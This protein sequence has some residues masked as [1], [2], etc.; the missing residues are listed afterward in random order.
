MLVLPD[1][2]VLL[3]GPHFVTVTS[4]G[5][6]V[7]LGSGF[8]HGCAVILHEFLHLGAGHGADDRV[9]Q[10]CSKVSSDMVTLV[11]GA[12]LPERIVTKP[13][14][15]AA[16]AQVG[17]IGDVARVVVG[18]RRTDTAR[19]APAAAAGNARNTSTTR[20]APAARNTSDP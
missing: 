8:V 9:L 17:R 2:E 20:T 18:V 16:A 12:I 3:E 13:N 4:G 19:N 7:E 1:F 11:G 15:D 5:G 14:G 6:E 10:H